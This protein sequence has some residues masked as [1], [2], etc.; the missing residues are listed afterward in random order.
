MLGF[1]VDT[2]ETGEPLRSGVLSFAHIVI[3]GFFYEQ[4]NFAILRY[5]RAFAKVSNNIR[6]IFRDMFTIRSRYTRYRMGIIMQ[7]AHKAYRQHRECIA[8][9]EQ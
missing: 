3:P 4:G 6:I 1:C 8:L 7:L 2:A 9:G 5:K